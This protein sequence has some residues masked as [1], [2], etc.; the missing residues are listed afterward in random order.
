M[1][2][3]F[4]FEVLMANK[5]FANTSS[6][7]IVANN[8]TNLTAIDKLKEL[9]IFKHFLYLAFLNQRLQTGG[10]T[11]RDLEAW[12]LNITRFKEKGGFTNRDVKTFIVNLNNN[13]PEMGR[14]TPEE[15]NFIYYHNDFNYIEVLANSLGNNGYVFDIQLTGDIYKDYEYLN[16]FRLLL[17]T[18]GFASIANS[19]F[20]ARP[21]NA[22]QILLDNYNK[23]DDLPKNAI[24]FCVTHRSRQQN[25]FFLY[26]MLTMLEQ[27]LLKQ[28]PKRIDI[29]EIEREKPTPSVQDALIN[30]NEFV[31][32]DDTILNPNA[33][34]AQSNS[35]DFYKESFV[36]VTPKDEGGAGKGDDGSSVENAQDWQQNDENI[37][38]SDSDLDAQGIENEAGVPPEKN[39]RLSKFLGAVAGKFGHYK[40]EILKPESK[41]IPKIPVPPKPKEKP[42]H[43]TKKGEASNLKVDRDTV[44]GMI[45]FAYLQNVWCD[46]TAGTLFKVNLDYRPL[47]IEN[48][49]DN[50]ADANQ[51]MLV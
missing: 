47:S 25:N 10:M 27:W 28:L 37:I 1:G 15:M 42:M 32:F 23:T 9:D 44:D 4:T 51:T 49:G 2:D 7:G 20:N 22:W 11:G 24:R 5:D 30:P 19:E 36:F 26:K 18:K 39:N 17:L 46:T 29:R 48:Q 8:H 21:C 16:G 3:D 40:K 38:D 12:H 14:L 6:I 41:P 34:I 33:N 13:V 31:I 45:N 43:S 50:D 35:D